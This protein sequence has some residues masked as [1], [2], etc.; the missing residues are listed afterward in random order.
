MSIISGIIGV[1]TAPLVK[2]I[3]VGCAVNASWDG[4]KK[5]VSHF[6]KDSVESQVWTLLS[7]TMAQFYQQIFE[8][9]EK[10][11]EFNEEIV[12]ASF[13]EQ[14]TLHKN[15]IDKKSLRCIVEQTIY[16]D[17]NILTDREY[18][19]WVSIFADNCSK[20]P[21][22]YEMYKIQKDI[23][24][25][26]FTERNF[27]IQR[28]VAKLDIFVGNE[29]HTNKLF[30]S[31]ITN[32]NRLFNSSWKNEILDMITK[33][34]YNNFNKDKITNKM[35]FIDGNEDCELVLSALQSLF[36]LHNLT[37]SP[38]KLVKRLKNFFRDPHFNKVFIVTG[39]AGA[40]KSFFIKDYIVSA[41][42]AIEKNNISILPCIV[43]IS[44][45]NCFRNFDD[46]V[47]AELSSF[48]GKKLTT[49]DE[50]S[51]FFRDLPAK[52]CFVIDNL[53]SQILKK[54]D[55]DKL[56]QGIKI[57]SKFEQFRW[58]ISIDEYEYYYL[59]WDNSFLSKYCITQTDM[60]LKENQTSTIFCNA[61]S[62]DQYN[63]DRRIV[64]W[65]LKSQYGMAVQQFPLGITTPKE[66]H[67]FG[68]AAPKGE[69]IGIPS[70]YYDY[71]DKIVGWKNTALRYQN[72]NG[73]ENDLRKIIDFIITNHICE[74]DGLDLSTIDLIP[75]RKVQLV[76]PLFIKSTSMFD[77]DQG[78]IKT[79]Y[80]IN[81]F[82]FWAA[83]MI[84]MIDIRD[85]QKVGDL[86]SFPKELTE[87]LIPC[88]IFFYFESYTKNGDELFD[89]FSTLNKQHV[90]DY[91]LFC[92][93][94]A[95][96]VFSKKL[97]E[98]LVENMKCYIQGA[99]ECYSVLY[100][101]FFSKLKIAEKLQLLNTIS[102][103][104]IK[105]GFDRLYERIFRSIIF[106]SKEEKKLKKNVLE[107]ALCRVDT[108]NYINGSNVGAKYLEL[109][110]KKGKELETIVWDIINYINSHP[111][112]LSTI[113]K[114]GNNESFM[115][116]FIRR[117]FEVYLFKEEYSVF[118][119]YGRLQRFFALEAPFGVYVKRNLTCAAGNMFTH[120]KNKKY[121][122][123]Y[124]SL[125]RSFAEEDDL[126]QRLTSLFLITNSVDEKEPNL[127]DQLKSILL[128]LSFDKRINTKH[129][130][131]IERLLKG[132]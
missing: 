14:F 108:V 71:I 64:E 101:V 67:Y 20:Y 25:N 59:E 88:A 98:Y 39:T 65:I 57:F 33:L 119:L 124:I 38:S 43:D 118:D 17:V 7:D 58:M 28:V 26:I 16:G 3:L 76:N 19:L 5:I 90:L 45:I 120:P 66:A 27:M 129:K 125:T 51:V 30:E 105:F 72:S 130:S 77:L 29:N 100:F 15:S 42:S 85:L 56:I 99:K 10:E 13:L 123:D 9:F 62:I 131:E 112:L 74:L 132:K 96:I 6:K 81:I 84:K 87:W 83:K 115:D 107:V 89:F 126:Y 37:K 93:N 82:P 53:N 128:E 69:M 116:Y 61:F 86:V 55:W 49:I 70:T 79:S 34:S 78:V 22:L 35:D 24:D 1:L 113:T 114:E 21:Q 63:K 68:E 94:K 92:A 32:L 50:A 12:V 36:N 60:Q 46:F 44:R 103:F 117:C 127:N 110:W 8:K 41:I 106:N 80:K 121:I 109:A 52:V 75:F 31:V 4:I 47:I 11:W 91:A 122:D 23:S 95:S 97:F 2:E 104:I 102:E 48:T 111:R 40:G 73:I 18:Q 54:E